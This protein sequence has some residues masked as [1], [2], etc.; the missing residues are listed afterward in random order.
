MIFQERV[1]KERAYEKR[2]WAI[3]FL[4]MP[5]TVIKRKQHPAHEQQ[6]HLSGI[7]IFGLSHRKPLADGFDPRRLS[8]SIFRI[9]WDRQE[10]VTHYR[11]MKIESQTKREKFLDKRSGVY[12][13]SFFDEENQDLYPHGFP[14]HS[15]CWDLIERIVGPNA[16]RKLDL[17]V[18]ILYQR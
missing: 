14:V 9:P 12:K 7:S 1:G 6:H 18:R 3:P 8:N 5:R 10:V 4:L 13:A 17:F 15:H 2:M 11:H 16:E